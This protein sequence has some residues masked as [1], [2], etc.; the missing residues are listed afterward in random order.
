MVKSSKAHLATA[1]WVLPLLAW[2]SSLLNGV[3]HLPLGAI[4]H[5]LLALAELGMLVS[6]LIFGIIVLADRQARSCPRQ[7]WSAII[8]LVLSG[9]TFVVIAVAIIIALLSNLRST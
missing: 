4:L 7:K 1:A 9:G 8:G 2:A 6:S 5:F 3:L